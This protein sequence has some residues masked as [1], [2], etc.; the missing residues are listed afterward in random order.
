MKHHT[1]RQANKMVARCCLLICVGLALN[2]QWALEQPDSSLMT[3]YKTFV[4]IREKMQELGIDF[5]M[6]H[7]EMGAYSAKSIKGT[8]LY[9]SSAWIKTLNRQTPP[10]VRRSLKGKLDVASIHKDPS[11]GK[12]GVTG[13]KDLK[14]TQAYTREFGWNVAAASLESPMVVLDLPE[15]PRAP[16]SPADAWQDAA[17][18]DVLPYMQRLAD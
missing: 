15:L 3:V 8:H 18:E 16:L 6:T 1:I 13:G 11:T 9:S 14:K 5:V 17:L 7:C 12:K 4:F 10:H 2:V